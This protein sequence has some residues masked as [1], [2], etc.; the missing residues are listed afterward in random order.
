MERFESEHWARSSFD[1]PMILL[2]HIVEIL[3]SDGGDLGGAAKALK[4]FVD[5]F[6]P[7]PIG[8]TFADH[9]PQRDSATSQSLRKE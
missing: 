6:D 5:L 3:G 4:D 1:K 9:N 2:N 7:S 8:P